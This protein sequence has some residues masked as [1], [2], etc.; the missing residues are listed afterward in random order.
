MNDTATDRVLE[1]LD[2]IN[3]VPRQS[4][5]L[6]KIHPWLMAWGKD[7]GFETLSDEA[8]NV[9]IRVPATPGYESA[10]TLVLQGH[11][12][13]VCEKRPDVEHDFQKDPVVSRRDGEWLR[14]EG[15]SLGADNGIALALF[16]DL[17]TDDAAEHPALEILI[18]ADEETGLVGAQNLRP[19][20]LSGSVLLNLD[21]E[22]EGV[23]TVGC[24]GGMDTN[25][26]LPVGR[27]AVPAGYEVR[28][29]TVGGLE[30][31]HSGI[32]IHVGKANANVLLLRALRSVLD[33]VG[34]ARIGELNGGTAHNAIPREASAL[35]AVPFG[36]TGELES[37]VSSLEVVLKSENAQIETRLFLK[38]ERGEAPKTGLFSSGDAGRLVDA[39]RLIPH[40][41]K[42][43]STLI[44]GM[45]DTS[46]NFAV[47]RTEESAVKVLTNRRSAVMSRGA[48]FSETMFGLARLY[49][50][51]YDTGNHYPPWEPRRESEVM[52][53]SK[54]VWKD[55]FGADPEVEVTHAGL[56]CGAIGSKY[57]KLDMIS[58]GPTI[59]Q[60]HSPDERLHIPSLGRVRTFFRELLKSYRA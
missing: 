42:A 59:L 57:P 46:M 22:D 27:D 53:R 50:G 29:L 26:T 28:R 39:L 49:G 37:L 52:D 4:H 3:A 17:V 55:L 12:D 56:E 25:L 16:F 1:I 2:E 40:G 20:F 24:A 6:E 7:H 15:T 41:V 35:I 47:L 34:E 45:V 51:S 58:F 5:H 8:Q 9:L 48:D 10:P 19:D 23:F 44:E 31:G 38:L 33:A 14:A 32:E 18:T 60:P 43:M 11:M 36:R 30:G 21:S 54:R 13:M